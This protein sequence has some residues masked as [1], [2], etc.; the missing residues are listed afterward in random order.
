MS[1][2]PFPKNAT[3]TPATAALEAPVV[4]FPEVAMMDPESMDPDRVVSTYADTLMTG[5]FGD[6]DRILD[7][8]EETLT[9]VD[10]ALKA[11]PS[12]GEAAIQPLPTQDLSPSPEPAPDA[13][14]DPSLATAL[15][16]FTETA[17]YQDPAPQTAM[18]KWF[19]R[20]LLGC[21]AL[22]LAGVVG[23]LWMGQRPNSP[24]DVAKSG[25]AAQSDAE[26]LAYLQRSLEAIEK[27][28][29]QVEADTAPSP[30]PRSTPSPLPPIGFS[31]QG[32]DANIP[33]RIN[34]IERVY[35]PYQTTPPTLPAAP[36]ATPPTLVT[37]APYTNPTTPDAPPVASVPSP[38]SPAAPGITHVLVGVLELGDRSAALFDINGVSQRVYIG[39]R[40]GNAGWSLVSVSNQEAVVRRNGE[41]RS[42]YI[43]QQF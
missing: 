31:P 34:V 11:P 12:P 28:V 26:F 8:D 19:D 2:D 9:A 5:L 36:T 41:V 43:G 24:R 27:Q 1:P 42:I 4:A 6:L 22:S 14:A 16:A 13:E 23:L 7:G 39:E 37:P 15:A 3:L 18:G 33:G 17:D 32:L 10:A 38:A 29:A 25:T 20:L 21:T 35:I 30:A 40:I